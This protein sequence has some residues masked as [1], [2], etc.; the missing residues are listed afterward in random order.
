M[1]IPFGIAGLRTLIPGYAGLASEN[2]SRLSNLAKQAQ[3][4]TSRHGTV[5]PPT[6]SHLDVAEI[7]AGDAPG[8]D[9][10]DVHALLQD[11]SY[12]L[13][14]AGHNPNHISIWKDPRMTSLAQRVF[15]PLDEVAEEV[16]KAGFGGTAGVTAVGIALAL[17][18]AHPE[19]GLLAAIFVGGTLAAAPIS[20]LLTAMDQDLNT[21]AGFDGLINGLLSGDETQRRQCYDALVYFDRIPEANARLADLSDRETAT[22]HAAWQVRQEIE[23][24]E[25][26]RH[27]HR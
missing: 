14:G 18:G 3:P 12:D 10:D 22:G 6:L 19:T 11:I 20:D 25:Q 27:Q 24:W 13:R 26:Q 8:E 17:S 4:H 23:R 16:V 1:G 2:A 7:L 15:S 21:R 9:S 5:I